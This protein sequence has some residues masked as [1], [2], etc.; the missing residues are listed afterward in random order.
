MY[1]LGAI[2]ALFGH[3]QIDIGTY[4]FGQIFVSC[5]HLMTHYCNEFFDL[6]ADRA[7]HAR[8]GVTGGSRVLADGLL[9]PDVSIGAAFVLLF[10]GAAL[11]IGM[12]SGAAQWMC[13]AIIVLA[14]FY[15]A[16]P[17][18][19][20]HRGL[21]E[22]CSMIVIDVLCPALAF[23]LQAGRLEWVL[24]MVLLPNCIIQYSYML[25]M[26]LFD[27]EGD[28]A[29]GKKTLVVALG[30]ELSARLYVF[31]HVLAY[32]SIVVL[33][34]VGLPGTVVLMMGLTAPYS[35]WICRQ[36]LEGAHRRTLTKDRVA[37]SA[38]AYTMV[39]AVVMSLGLLMHPRV[40]WDQFHLTAGQILCAMVP[41]VCAAWLL[42]NTWA[43]VRVSRLK[44]REVR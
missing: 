43:K 41:S 28:R 39:V 32:A 31:S 26:N 16:P 18:K 38:A 29:A 11:L 33:W 25:M 42:A 13:F 9:S 21:G 34:W 30:P 14:W 6:E 4:L 37:W 22:L 1:G 19:F 20:N 24:F 17:F 27:H 7:N 15:T 44:E 36:V 35:V 10:L 12:P 3:H 23:Y 8:A 2:A 40:E 5:V